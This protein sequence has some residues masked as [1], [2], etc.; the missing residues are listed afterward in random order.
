ME[1]H[2]LQF[3]ILGAYKKSLDRVHQVVKQTQPDAIIN[4]YDFMGGF[5]FRFYRPKNIKHV[6]IGRQ[7]LTLHP[8]Y[9]FE[10][11]RE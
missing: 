1:I 5:Y 11:D 9:I 7:F 4:F 8:D 2:N 3:K 6:C 10:P